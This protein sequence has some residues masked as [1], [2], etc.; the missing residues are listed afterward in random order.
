MAIAPL[1]YHREDESLLD[2]VHSDL[3]S[4]AGELGSSY[5]SLT[6]QQVATMVV[7]V[8]KISKVVDYLQTLAA[9]A[10]EDHELS[11]SGQPEPYRSTSDYLRAKI[12]I[13][14][15]EANRRLRLG[16]NVFAEIPGPGAAVEASMATL[17]DAMSSGAV[18]G[19][20]ATVICDAVQRVRSVATSGQLASMEDHLTRQAIESDEDI[21]R[22]LA[23]R[24]SRSP[25]QTDDLV[26]AGAIGLIKAV[27]GFDLERGDDLG[28]YAVTTLH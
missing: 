3:L 5:L 26:Q 15:S 13:S 16:S 1:E 6:R 11:T 23:R 10:A 14:R 7:D 4:F 20:A 9:R 28:A 2:A 25:E 22:A 8:E 18:S 27:D 12:G 24:F 21:L 19:R 17:G